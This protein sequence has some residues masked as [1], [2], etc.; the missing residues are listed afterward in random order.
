MKARTCL[1]CGELLTGRIDRKFCSDACRIAYNNRV[2]RKENV[3][4]QKINKK[5]KRNRDILKALNPEGKARVSKE[6]LLKK[7][8]SFNFFTH[9]LKTKK[10]QVYTFVYEY[11]YLPLEDGMFFLVKNTKIVEE[12]LR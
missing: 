12:E 3:F 2:Y 11:G 7:G 6:D 4:I 8:F 10:G 9:Q 5:L 1:E